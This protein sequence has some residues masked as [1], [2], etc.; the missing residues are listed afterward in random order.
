M[1]VT[2]L[3][4][5]PV[6]YDGGRLPISL[7]TLQDRLRLLSENDWKIVEK[8]SEFFVWDRQP[9]DR[10]DQKVW[11]AFQQLRREINNALARQVIDYR[12]DMRT[13]VAG[14]RRKRFNE[15][16]MDG[17][18]ELASWIRRHWNQPYFELSKRYPWI[19][20]FSNAVESGRLLEAQQILFD[21]L[22]TK[23]TRLAQQFHFTLETIILY[24][25]RW[26]IVERWT[27]L[28]ATEGR[29]RFDFLLS[30]TMGEYAN[31]F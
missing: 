8:L 10:T 23:W 15:G 27:S 7:H 26:E 24:I 2:S 19:V 25:A 11:E 16:P 3:P 6:R 1:L 18:G 14:L 12:I 31:L 4:S 9:L 13:V 5:L 17:F 21:D 28:D 30:E 22:W 20:A 29:R